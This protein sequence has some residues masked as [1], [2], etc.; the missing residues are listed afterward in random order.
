MESESTFLNETINEETVFEATGEEGLASSSDKPSVANSQDELLSRLVPPLCYLCADM[1]TLAPGKLTQHFRQTHLAGHRTAVNGYVIALCKLGC[2]GGAGSHYHCPHP[3]CFVYTQTKNRLLIHYKTHLPSFDEVSDF[4]ADYE[5][6]AIMKTDTCRPTDS[7]NLPPPKKCYPFHG[8][9]YFPH[10]SIRPSAADL[11]E[12][13]CLPYCYL[14]DGE[15]PAYYYTIGRLERHFRMAHM[16]RGVDCGSCYLVLCGLNCL[17]GNKFRKHYHC[18]FCIPDDPKRCVSTSR[19]RF[20]VHLEMHR[21]EMFVPKSIKPTLKISGG[22][23]ALPVLKRDFRHSAEMNNVISE[24]NW[25]VTFHGQPVICHPS[26]NTNENFFYKMAALP[27][28]F[29]CND[30]KDQ[31]LSQK[32]SISHQSCPCKAEI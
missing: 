12:Y 23:R 4:P 31:Y 17:P 3:T 9:Q 24:Q 27:T 1:K 16:N 21:R 6:R 2:S 13:L 32:T 26:I 20:W 19:Y 28:C 10:A 7:Q 8:I 15:N 22:N 18:P 5:E 11:F 30:D 14:C 29:L 25:N